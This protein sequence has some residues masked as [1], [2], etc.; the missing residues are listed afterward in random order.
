MNLFSMSKIFTF[1]FLWTCNLS[2]SLVYF[3]IFP[4]LKSFLKQKCVTEWNFW[5]WLMWVIQIE[6]SI[7]SNC[8]RTWDEMYWN[9]G[10]LNKMC[11]NW[12]KICL[13]LLQIEV[14]KSSVIL[15]SKLFHFLILQ[16]CLPCLWVIS[17]FSQNL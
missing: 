9:F 12:I 6:K 4:K 11:S 15:N 13:R 1:S 17:F 7:K 3:N 5:N 14:D 10:G 2:Q 8:S 16:K